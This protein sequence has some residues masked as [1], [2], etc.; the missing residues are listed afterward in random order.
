MPRTNQTTSITQPTEI[1]LVGN[2]NDY[3]ITD[4]DYNSI[5]D[6]FTKQEAAESYITTSVD[7]DDYKHLVVYKKVAVYKRNTT[8]IKLDTDDE[9]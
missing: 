5:I 3:L 9:Y 2:S 6:N 1:T 4:G 7:D 8:F